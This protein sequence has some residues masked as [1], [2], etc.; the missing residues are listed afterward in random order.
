MRKSGLAVL[1]LLVACTSPLESELRDLVAS[2][3]LWL[4]SAP[5]QNYS[6]EYVHFCFCPGTSG[7]AFKVRV[8]QAKVVSVAPLQSETGD[9]EFSTDDF[10]TIWDL[11]GQILQLIER[12]VSEGITLNVE[13]DPDLGY[14]KLIEWNNRK[15]ADAFGTVEVRK[16]IVE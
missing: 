5:A 2:K 3:E 8:A 9:R 10:P 7:K 14:P 1:L 4:S 15:I 6:F 16:V 13:Y 11:Q 12:S